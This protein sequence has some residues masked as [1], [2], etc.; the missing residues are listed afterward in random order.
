LS[1][2]DASSFTVSSASISDIAIGGDDSFTVEPDTG[3]AAN[4]YIATVTV[5]SG[6]G[7]T[8]TFEVNFTVNAV[9]ATTYTITFNANGGSISPATGTTGTDGKLTSLPTPTRS[10]YSFDAWFTAASG[11]TQIT[12]ATVFSANDTVYAHWT[13]T[14]GGGGG[15]SNPSG[16]GSVNSGGSSGTTIP[17]D[18]TPAANS[19]VKITDPKVPLADAPWLNPFTDVKV[20]DWFYADV[21]YAVTNGLFHG[22]SATTFSP[23]IAMTRGMIVTV[24]YRLA[25]SPDVSALANPFSD[26][27]EGQYYTD[28]VKWAAEKGIVS[29]IGDNLFAPEKSVTRQDL[30]VIILRYADFA[31]L[32]LPATQPYTPFNDEAD[33]A[34]YAKEAVEALFK[35]DIVSGKPGNLYDPQGTATRAEVAAILHR[36]ILAAE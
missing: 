19:E 29:G 34:G 1:G 26:V 8:A 24:L 35:A 10:S 12:T 25:G 33:I 6:N 30:A 32:K 17:D 4:T 9:P 27:A 7:I 20:G 21:E 15:G 3:L 16:G 2:T 13:S 5:S 31:G 28:A 14:G 18:Q 11:G 36:F 23:N 22:T